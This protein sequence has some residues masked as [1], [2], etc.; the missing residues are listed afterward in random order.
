[1]AFYGAYVLVV[2]TIISYA[3]PYLR[4][5]TANSLA[6]QSLEKK[7]FWV[8]SIGMCVMVLAL[9]VAGVMQSYLQ[10]WLPEGQALSFMAGQ[11]ELRSYYWLRVAGGVTFLIGQLMYFASF[12]VGGEHASSE[13]AKL[14]A[15]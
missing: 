1:M 7:S 5:R 2:I 13:N 15:A 6:A 8:M 3:M 14:Q 11:D 12:F 4:G 9:T 10:R